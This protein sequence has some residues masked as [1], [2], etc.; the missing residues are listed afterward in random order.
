M[1]RGAQKS[2]VCNCDFTFEHICKPKLLLVDDK[3]NKMG[4]TVRLTTFSSNIDTGIELA[5]MQPEK[6]HIL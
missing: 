3:K 2:S 1:V 6:T 5:T 4:R